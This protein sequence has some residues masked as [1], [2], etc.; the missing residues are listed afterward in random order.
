MSEWLKSSCTRSFS[1]C[2]HVFCQYFPARWRSGSAPGDTLCPFV[3]S[4]SRLRLRDLATRKPLQER[5]WSCRWRTCE[6]TRISRDSALV[7]ECG[8]LGR[9]IR[10]CVHVRTNRTSMC[11][12][13]ALAQR[14]DWELRESAPGIVQLGE[15][16]RLRSLDKGEARFRRRTLRRQERSQ[17]R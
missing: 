6:R 15:R 17:C 3:A 12:E 1:Y 4:E 2:I 10:R 5:R 16:R 11:A 7:P 9:P 14:L 13:L 8:E